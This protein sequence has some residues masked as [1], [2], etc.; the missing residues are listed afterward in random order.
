MLPAY[1]DDTLQKVKDALEV[2]AE[3]MRHDDT[4]LDFPHASIGFLP[5]GGSWGTCH[6]DMEETE[7]HKICKAIDAILD[8]MPARQKEAVEYFHIVGGIKPSRWSI[9]EAYELAIFKIEIGLRSRGFI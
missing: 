8:G 2:W 5:G 7:D 1:A 4:D 9:E 3:Y 6:E